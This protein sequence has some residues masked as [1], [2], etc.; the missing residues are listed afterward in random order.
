V[1][2][3]L[4]GPLVATAGA[5][6]AEVEIAEAAGAPVTW[7]A[8]PLVTPVG[9]A[10]AVLRLQGRSALLDL[11]ARSGEGEL[12]FP[13]QPAV[14]GDAEAVAAAAAAGAAERARWAAAWAAGDLGIIDAEGR[15]VGGL[16][17]RGPAAPAEVWVAD[18]LWATAGWAAAERVQEGGDLLLAFP[19]EP[20]FGDDIGL[21]RILVGT[22]DVIVPQSDAPDADDRRLRLRPTGATDAERA[23]AD[24]AARAEAEAAEAA[25]LREHLPLLGAGLAAGG[26]CRPIADVDPAWPLLLR[27]YAVELTTAAGGC[28]VQLVPDP[29]QHRRRLRARWAPGAGVQTGPE[30][31]GAD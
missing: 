20:A 22:G 30:P 2:L 3:E 29:P 11:G 18:G 26:G 1:E 15:L 28:A 21:L 12:V 31:G 4:A 17:L 7:L 27:G 16:R 8:F 10:E 14:P 25:W 5:V 13:L 9:D 6:R 19:V 23:A 24:A